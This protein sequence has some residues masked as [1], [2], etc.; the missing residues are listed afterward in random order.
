MQKST[1]NIA[2]RS[3]NHEINLKNEKLICHLRNNLTNEK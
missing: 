1:K 3:L 2:N